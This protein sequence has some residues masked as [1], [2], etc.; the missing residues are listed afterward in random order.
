MVRM[1]RLA[2]TFT[3]T[4]GLQVAE[5]RV[6]TVAQPD[7]NAAEPAAKVLRSNNIRLS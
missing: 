5:P 4:S 1:T 2:S 6:P 3:G 7:S